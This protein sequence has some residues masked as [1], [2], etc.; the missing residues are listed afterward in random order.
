MLPHY[1]GSEVPAYE[2]GVFWC[3]GAVLAECPSSRHQLLGNCS[4]DAENVKPV[5]VFLV[6]GVRTDIRP[7]KLRAKLAD[8]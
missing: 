2:V 7:V 5:C 4:L 1:E 3:T 8:F 6:V